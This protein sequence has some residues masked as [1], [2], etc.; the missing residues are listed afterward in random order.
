VIRALGLLTV[1]LGLV[2]CAPAVLRPEQ[3]R[4]PRF[5]PPGAL[6]GGDVAPRWEPRAALGNHSPYRVFG[7]EYR[8]LPSAE[9]FQEQGVASWYGRKFHGRPTSSG[10]PYDM[11]ALTAAHKHLPLPTYVRVTR[12]DTGASLVVKVN[13]RGPFHDDRIIDLSYAAAKRL[14]FDQQGT[15]QV[16]LEAL[17]FP[18]PEAV[19]EPG[20]VPVAPSKGLWLQAGAFVDA[21]AAQSLLAA[22]EPLL[23]MADS[24]APASIRH[25]PPPFHRVHIGPFLDPR[26]AARVQALLTFSD[27]LAVPL[28]IEE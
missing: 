12:E 24:P 23:A 21:A 22:L 26:A 8:V 10:E 18:A 27:L 25:D 13:D 4:G 20:P 15:A 28:L 5:T 2:S 6:R 11:F 19:A 9:G 17:T 16:R 14:G 1:V 7:V 3:D